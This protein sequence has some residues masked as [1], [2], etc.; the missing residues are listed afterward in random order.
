M[1]GLLAHLV[2]LEFMLAIVEK[3]KEFS[4]LPLMNF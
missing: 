2:S 4:V 3:A 1:L